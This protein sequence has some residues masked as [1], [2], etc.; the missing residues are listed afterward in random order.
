MKLPVTTSTIQTRFFDTDALGH[1]S[2]NAY[3]QYMEL[4]RTDLFIEISKTSHVPIT[5][6]VNL[7]IDYVGEIQF[8]EAITAVSW[9]SKMG[10]KSMVVRSDILAGERVAARGTV[11]MVGFDTETRSSI[12]LPSDWE[13]SDYHPKE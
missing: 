13:A 10:N 2:S 7:N 12:V 8:G 5:A 6:V 3:F 11:I 9:C 1:I 4:A